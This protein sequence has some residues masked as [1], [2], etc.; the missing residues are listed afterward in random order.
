LIHAHDELTAHQCFPTGGFGPDEQLLPAAAWR[1]KTDY[2]HNSFETQCGVFAVFKLC[3]Y[4]MMITGD[5]RYGD[6]IER[7]VYNGLAATIPMTP[8]GRVFYYSDYCALGGSKRNHGVGWSCCTGTRPMALADLHDLVYF[9]SGDGL[10]VNLYVPSTLDWNRPDGRMTVRQ[11][12]RFPEEDAIE[13]TITARRPVM[14]SLKLRSP[15]WLAGPLEVTVS[16]EPVP[17]PVDAHGWATVRRMW[18]SG[19][20]VTVRLPQRFEKKPLDQSAPFPAAI[21][22]GPV[23]LAIRPSARNPGALLQSGDLEEALLPSDG[24]P[25]T[26]HAR[27]D[28]D[29]LVRPFYAFKQGEPYSLYLD[30]NRY[31]HTSAQFSG[32]HWRAAE[33]FRFNDHP[34]ASVEFSFTGTGVRWIGYRFDDAGLAQVRIDGQPV[35]E[36]DQYGPGRDQPFEWRKAGLNRGSH[37]LVLTILDQ[38]PGASKGRFIN[39]AGFEVTP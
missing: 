22:R 8:D 31:S 26:Y 35:A 30:P 25:L 28:Q 13:L 1:K 33:S 36:V 15:G 23:A 2:T 32:D 27:S 18:R 24:E 5:A 39:V 7:L 38:K 34:G 9:H 3:K 12:T 19:T 17:A 14:F 6:W 29:L 16:G 10:Y 20:R 37:H 4:L 21:M 11:R